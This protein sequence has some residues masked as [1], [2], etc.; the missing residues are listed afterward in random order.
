MHSDLVGPARFRTELN[1]TIILEFSYNLVVSGCCF[2]FQ[3]I[4]S[5]YRPGG[6][7]AAMLP[8]RCIYDSVFFFESAPH[9]SNVSFLHPPVFEHAFQIFKSILILSSQHKAGCCLVQAMHYA[10]SHGFPF[11]IL[12][13][14]AIDVLYRRIML[15]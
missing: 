8:Y 12:S 11:G 2:F 7:A 6:L 9:Q 15:Q 1:Q 3:K 5:H 13:V 14:T 10:G 4:P